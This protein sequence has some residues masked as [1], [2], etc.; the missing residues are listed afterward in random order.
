MTDVLDV[1]GLV[2]LVV[3]GF[4][5]APFVGA[6]MVGASC[7]GLSWSVTRRRRKAAEAALIKAEADR[8]ARLQR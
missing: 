3:M 6:G 2:A 5:I 4:L 7:L 8:L 1:V